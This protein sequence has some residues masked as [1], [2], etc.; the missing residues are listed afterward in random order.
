MSATSQN[1]E[2]FYDYEGFVE[3]FKPKLTTDDCYTPPLVYQAVAEWVANQYN[4]DSKT[5]AR[6]FYPGVDYINYDYSG[7]IVVDNPP[8]SILI[9]IIKYYIEKGI[10]FFLFAPT[11]SGLV[12]YSDVCTALAVGVDITY[13]NGAVIT[14]SFVTN[15]ESYEIRMKTAPTLYAAVKAAND[16]NRKKITK[17]VPKYSYPCKLVTSAAIYPYNKYGIEFSIPRPESVRVGRLDAQ[18]ESKKQIFGCGLLISDRLT[19]EREKAEREKAERFPLSPRERDIIS[20]LG[21]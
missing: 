21:K 8:F 18:R 2:S 14:T 13:E 19:A 15:M 4:V 16:E 11:L 1:K 6:P 20:K 7:K 3:K 5:F 9:K 17:T 10:E 12:R